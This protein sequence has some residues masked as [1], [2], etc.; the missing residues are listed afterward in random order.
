MLHWSSAARSSHPESSH[1]S[2][3]PRLPRQRDA[4]R[5]SSAPSPAYRLL[6]TSA[7]H[8]PCTNFVTRRLPVPPLLTIQPIYA[9]QP[10]SST[11]QLEHA[12]QQAL[13]IPQPPTP[14]AHV[15]SS[16]DPHPSPPATDILY[17]VPAHSLPNLKHLHPEQPSITIHQPEDS[18]YHQH[19]LQTHAGQT[20][21][22]Q[23]QSVSFLLEAY[24][25]PFNSTLDS[26]T[27]MG[28]SRILVIFL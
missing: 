27:A 23:G 15:P 11:H 6:A 1:H 26:I 21:P 12:M 20:L 19:S 22:Q 18:I 10:S 7:F 16:Q 14:V 17:P 8:C 5:S 25:L 4:S 9:T 2:L 13:S 28:C 3:S 24:E